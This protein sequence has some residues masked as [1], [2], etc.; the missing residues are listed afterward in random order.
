MPCSPAAWASSALPAAPNPTE[1]GVA[2][3]DHLRPDAARRSDEGETGDRRAGPRA[4]IDD[5]HPDVQRA[6]REELL[7]VV[8]RV[9]RDGKSAGSRR[10]GG[11]VSLLAASGRV[12][13]RYERLR[14][15]TLNDAVERWVDRGLWLL[16]IYGGLTLVATWTHQPDP[17]VDLAA[18]SEYVTTG[19][20]YVSHLLGSLLG[21]AIGT[22]GVVALGL[23]VAHDGRRPRAA[24]TAVV[25]HVVGA[26]VVLALFGVAAFVQP[27]MGEAFL[28]GQG[29][30]QDWHA[31]VF[32]GSS[33]L[34]PALVGL[35]AFSSA[36][37]VTAW[38]LRGVPRVPSWVAATYGVSAPLIGLFG[39]AVGVLQTV[40]SLALVVGG[41]S[42]AV[43]L[44]RGG[45][46]VPRSG[47]RPEA[48]PSA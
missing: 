37:V 20:F 19:W 39:V 44:R 16:P 36:S 38:A 11:Q 5:E 34:G 42:L 4:G 3:L 22:L 31:A 45:S 12:D 40:G 17:A 30:V 35:V 9:I 18:W 21:L 8:Y 24:M 2:A 41:V 13:S 1:N 29:A 33:T 32:D 28:A 10:A 6:G 15:A 48:Q 46:D 43:R 26:A 25:L 7:P 23:R 14:G 27:A 47:R